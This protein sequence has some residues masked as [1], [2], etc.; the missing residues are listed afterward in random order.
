MCQLEFSTLRAKIMV[1]FP[2]G[3]SETI[4]LYMTSTWDNKLKNLS[5]LIQRSSKCFD[6]IFDYYNQDYSPTFFTASLVWQ[7]GILPSWA[8]TLPITDVQKVLFVTAKAVCCHI[9]AI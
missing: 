9:T 5:L 6:Y 2:S 3:T 7:A 8:G 4:H 1:K